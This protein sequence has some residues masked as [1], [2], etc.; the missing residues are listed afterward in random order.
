MLE[1]LYDLLQII[2]NRLE[3]ETGLHQKYPD[4]V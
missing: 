2:W 3:V 1:I 4:K